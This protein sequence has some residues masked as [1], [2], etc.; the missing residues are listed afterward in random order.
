MSAPYPPA[1]WRDESSNVTAMKRAYTEANTGQQAILRAWMRGVLEANEA[2][3]NE[4]QLRAMLAKRAAR[5]A[6]AAATP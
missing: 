2:T 1:S 5:A 4:R 6:R 3:L